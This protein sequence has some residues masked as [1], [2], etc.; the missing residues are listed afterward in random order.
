MNYALWLR[1]SALGEPGA[2]QRFTRNRGAAR[3][4]CQDHG[5]QSGSH[6]L[7]DSDVAEFFSP[8]LDLPY[9]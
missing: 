2:A 9:R 7:I 8:V 1:A 6:F 4:R 5:E 3:G